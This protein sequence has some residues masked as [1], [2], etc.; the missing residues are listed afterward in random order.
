MIDIYNSMLWAENEE[1][2]YIPYF[3]LIHIYCLL[4]TVMQATNASV[5]AQ[6]R[7]RVE[8]VAS[9]S[10]RSLTPNLF[11]YQNYQEL[12]TYSNYNDH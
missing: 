9:T 8:L 4:F 3:N 5:R 1:K 6:T 10:Q 2:H 11:H 7:K 12:H